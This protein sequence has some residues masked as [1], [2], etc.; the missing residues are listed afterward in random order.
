MR[1]GASP[2][3]SEFLLLKST[4]LFTYYYYCASALYWQ[5]L[6]SV[7]GLDVQYYLSSNGSDYQDRFQVTYECFLRAVITF[8][9]RIQR[10]RYEQLHGR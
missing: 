10:T 8:A 2:K 6:C 1:Q 3:T 5:P 9:A 7:R 4:G